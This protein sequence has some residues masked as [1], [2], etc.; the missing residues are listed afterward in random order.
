MFPPLVTRC[1]VEINAKP[2]VFVISRDFDED[3]FLIIT[4]DYDA[5][6]LT[7]NEIA[8]CY[9]C[10]LMLIDDEKRMIKSIFEMRK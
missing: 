10:K 4:I 2:V 9:F 3:G 1:R 7:E 6:G 5:T 8:Q